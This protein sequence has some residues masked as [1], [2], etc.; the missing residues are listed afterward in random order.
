MPKTTLH[1]RESVV[2]DDVITVRDSAGAPIDITNFTFQLALM[3]QA[4]AVDFTLNAAAAGSH[5]LAVVDGEAGEL[6]IVIGQ[7]VLSAIGDTTG[8]FELFGDLLGTVP[9][10]AQL[11][12]GEVRIVV[13]TV[14][15]AFDGGSYAL[16]VGAIGPSAIKAITA[17]AQV[18]AD[19]AAAWAEGSVPGGAGTK[20]A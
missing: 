11:F 1:A 3:R 9:S 4:G 12:F 19:L 16:L 13:T 7:G 18:Q 5:G 20:S 2:F 17:A 14:G 6:R 8:S 15:N 10:G